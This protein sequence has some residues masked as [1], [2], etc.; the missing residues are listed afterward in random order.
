MHKVRPF[1]SVVSF[2]EGVFRNLYHFGGGGL[3]LLILV[4]KCTRNR[5]E[6]QEHFLG[7]GVKTAGT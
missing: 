1:T 7:W 2:R 3:L 5:N 4:A 6:Y